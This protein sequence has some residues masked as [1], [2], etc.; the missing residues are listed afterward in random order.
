M[1]V[2]GVLVLSL[3]VLAGY[4]QGADG[5]AMA[6][7]K[8][9]APTAQTCAAVRPTVN[10]QC[11]A[12]CVPVSSRT[13]NGRLIVGTFCDLG[14]TLATTS[15]VRTCARSDV[16][17]CLPSSADG[18]GSCMAGHCGPNRLPMDSGRIILMPDGDLRSTMSTRSQ[19]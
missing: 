1:R 17:I 4:G 3:I 9:A 12:G 19:R 7:A 10:T 13:V 15:G 16:R 18:G 6:Q 2:A 5:R 11:P 14:V 8:L